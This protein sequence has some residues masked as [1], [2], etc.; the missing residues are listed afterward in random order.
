M[1]YRSNYLRETIF[2]KDDA[3]QTP[4]C[5]LFCTMNYTADIINT[6]LG[7]KSYLL[8]VV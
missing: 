6:L 4:Q 8:Q 3:P 7:T 1:V 5:L 2:A